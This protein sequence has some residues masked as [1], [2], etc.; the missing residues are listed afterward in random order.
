[1]LGGAALS[2]II[3]G[4]AAAAPGPLPA[5]AWVVS[6]GDETCRTEID[7]MGRSGENARIGLVSDGSQVELRFEKDELPQRAFLPIRVDRKPFANLMIR[8]EDPRQGAMTLSPET[9]DAIR[10]GKALQIAWLAGEPVSATLEG[11]EQGIAD[12]ETCGAQVAAQHRAEAAAAQAEKARAEAE[13]RA[14]AVADEQLAAAK[15]Q[16]EAAEATKAR[17]T[18]EAERIRAAAE[19]EREQADAARRR[20]EAVQRAAAEN[21]YG[22]DGYG[23]PYRRRAGPPAWAQGPQGYRPAYPSDAYPSDDDSY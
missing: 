23:Y 3:V 12:L 8:R 4:W 14:Q 13:A 20:Q 11:S 22:D 9:L 21:G 10:H 19:A 6:P 15:A 7:L 2:A 5:Q 16:Q 18:A 17:E 1:M